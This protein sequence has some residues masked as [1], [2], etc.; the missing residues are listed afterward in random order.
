MGDVLSAL[1]DRLQPVHQQYDSVAHAL[2]VLLPDGLRGHCRIAGLA[3]GC[4]KV[5]AD[6]S[7]YVY[8]LQL[9]KGVLL[10]EL[11]RSCPGV[12][13]RRIEVGMMR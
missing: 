13:L 1:A 9:C 8:E 11:Q 2:E 6:G 3:N 5:E 7:T 10:G 4:L 12:R